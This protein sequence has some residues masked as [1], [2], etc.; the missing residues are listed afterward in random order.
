[1]SDRQTDLTRTL[2]KDGWEDFVVPNGKR[3]SLDH[4]VIHIICMTKLNLS[5][6]DPQR[7]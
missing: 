1:M 2:L 6:G 7:C 5:S 4:R 3:P